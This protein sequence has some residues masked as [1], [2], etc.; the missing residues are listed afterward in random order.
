MSP[1]ERNRSLVATPLAAGVSNK[2]EDARRWRGAESG[3][4]VID[5]VPQR[6]IHVVLLLHRERVI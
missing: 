4:G 6:E 5:A 3:S 2:P 1:G